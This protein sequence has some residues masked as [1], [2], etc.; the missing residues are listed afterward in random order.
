MILLL[1]TATARAG[2][3]SAWV[4]EGITGELEDGEVDESSGIAALHGWPGVYATHQDSDGPEELVLFEIDG[5]W[6]GTVPID[7]DIKSWDWEDI[8]GG[9]CP[10]GTG[11]DRC[12]FIADIGDNSAKREY[13]DVFVVPEPAPEDLSEL[14][15]LARYHLVYPEGP[16]DAETMFVHPCTGDV[17]IV[18]KTVPAEVW[19]VPD[20]ARDAEEPVP[21]ELVA[22]LAL[23]GWDLRNTSTTGGDWDPDGELLAIRTYGEV[24]LWTTDPTDPDAHW[25]QVPSSIRDGLAGEAIG[26][27][28]EGDLV[29]TAEGH[30]MPIERIACLDRVPGDACGT[31]QDT[32][33]PLDT[34]EGTAPAEALGAEEGRGCGCGPATGGG[35]AWPG[36]AMAAAWTR[37]RRAGQSPENR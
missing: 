4:D 31:R 1:L 6:R 21:M 30:P 3:C 14:P 9:P 8:S 35:L 25:S 26:F 28:L 37:R 27:S 2:T 22:T 13:V 17:Y 16:R 34:G 10:E 19:R 5:T 20:Q 12:I 11:H 33:A 32:G 36:L 24:L 18:T 15:V 7:P 29:G 23:D